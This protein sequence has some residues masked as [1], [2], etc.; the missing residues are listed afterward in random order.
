MPGAGL[1]PAPGVTSGDFKSSQGAGL[2]GSISLT[3]PETNQLNVVVR[4]HH[5]GSGVGA[6]STGSN[7]FEPIQILARSYGRRT[8]AAV[9]HEDRHFSP[10]LVL[11]MPNTEALSG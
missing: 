6:L 1:E 3:W 9:V 10:G 4:A 7:L 11:A 2:W 5:L 8:E